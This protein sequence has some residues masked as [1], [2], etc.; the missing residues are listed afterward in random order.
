MQA[1]VVSE[2]VR[3]TTVIFDLDEVKK[4]LLDH[5][6]FAISP[7]FFLPSSEILIKH[8]IDG[9]KLKISLVCV[10]SSMGQVSSSDVE[11]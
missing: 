7:D 8:H 5:F 9:D 3:R 1:N 2:T 4:A 10:Q 11:S 6:G